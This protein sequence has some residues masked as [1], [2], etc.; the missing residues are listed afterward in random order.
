M[1][2]TKK[3]YNALLDLHLDVC[4]ME[5]YGSEVFEIQIA[6]EYILKEY[7]HI[8]KEGNNER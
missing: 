7:K 4:E 1:N 6:I 3:L 8:E 5:G 2:D